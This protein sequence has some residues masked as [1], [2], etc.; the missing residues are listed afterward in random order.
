[1]QRQEIEQRLELLIDNRVNL[2]DPDEKWAIP[3]ANDRKI[4]N[5]KL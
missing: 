1:M 5:K 4:D 3:L 2:K